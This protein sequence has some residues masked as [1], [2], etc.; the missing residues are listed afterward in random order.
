[1]WGGYNRTDTREQCRTT[2]THTRIQAVDFLCLLRAEITKLFPALHTSQIILLLSRR[3]RQASRLIKYCV[4]SL[5]VRIAHDKKSGAH[6]KFSKGISTI[7]HCLS[8]PTTQDVK[9]YINRCSK[10]HSYKGSIHK[11]LTDSETKE[12]SECTVGSGSSSFIKDP[13]KDQM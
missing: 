1:M 13:P 9:T 2:Q 4:E 12:T 7:N 6:F 3:A 10:F 5:T 8:R 11:K